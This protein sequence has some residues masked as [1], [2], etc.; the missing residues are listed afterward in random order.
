MFACFPLFPFLGANVGIC[1]E[2]LAG[3]F[4]EGYISDT[5]FGV[6]FYEQTG[7]L[8]PGRLLAWNIWGDKG[9]NSVRYAGISF[10]KFCRKNHPE[11][12]WLNTFTVYRLYLLNKPSITVLPSVVLY[13][14]V[15]PVS[16]HSGESCMIPWF[17]VH[18]VMIYFGS[19]PA[20][21]VRVESKGCR[22]PLLN[23]SKCNIPGGD[24]ASLVGDEHKS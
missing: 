4:R 23:M 8:A 7:A 10:K 2:P 21:S 18:V 20:R 3:S 11:W 19:T 6:I 14:L 1:S 24:D 15:S 16:P 13:C 5:I 9:I 17:E 12:R 22:D